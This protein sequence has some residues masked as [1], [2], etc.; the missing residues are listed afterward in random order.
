MNLGMSLQEVVEAATW[1]PAQV[2]KREELGHLSEG[3]VADV[4]IFSLQ[5]GDFR[6]I[7]SRGFSQPGSQKLQPELTIRAGNVVWDLNGLAATPY[8]EE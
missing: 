8:E 7:D 6:F 4:A 3:A 2:I 1:K 5:E